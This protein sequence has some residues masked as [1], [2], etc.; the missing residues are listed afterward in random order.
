MSNPYKYGFRWITAGQYGRPMPQPQE[1]RFA[2]GY[3]G[4]INGGS[5]V[6]L[7]IG[8]PVRRLNSGYF[9]IADGNEGGSGGEDLY[10]VIVGFKQYYSATEGRIISA[11]HSVPGGTAYGTILERSTI[12]YVVPVDSGYFAVCADEATTAATE[13][14]FIA[15]LG[16]N[17]DHR[18]TTGSEP[19]A[20]PLLDISTHSATNGQWRLID[21]RRQVDTDY[22]S[23]YVELIV[24]GN[25]MA[26][27]LPGHSA[28]TGI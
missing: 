4:A 28:V 18:L 6:D 12:A 7:N 26:T 9:E 17:C 11:P 8:D 14:A 10:G 2:T 5:N 20:S 27:Q 24:T 15:L 22:T 16:E 13:A 25:E 23:A 21:I 1:A 3:Q 19:K